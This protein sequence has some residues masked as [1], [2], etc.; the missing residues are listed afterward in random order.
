M[1]FSMFCALNA[2]KFPKRE[3]LIE[4]YPSRGLRRGIDWKEF[5]D[6]T[7]KLA[8]YMV[9]ECGIKKGDI[10]RPHSWGQQPADTSKDNFYVEYLG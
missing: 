8:N 10:V 5:N 9:K 1:N 6:Q 3:F 4:S 7:N 2:S